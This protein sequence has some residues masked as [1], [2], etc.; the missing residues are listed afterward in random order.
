[1][2]VINNM[3]IE[4][5]ITLCSLIT[6]ASGLIGFVPA[7][8]KTRD[9]FKK[10]SKRSFDSLQADKD[11]SYVKTHTIDVQNLEPQ[12]ACPPEPNNVK[13]IS[14]VLGTPIT[15]IIIG[16]CTNG[17]ANDIKDTLKILMENKVK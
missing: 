13:P 14:E 7:D 3:T 4:E 16:S 11:A 5:R 9:F 1:M 17:T 12:I 15:S 10:Y 2:D 6:E 8:N